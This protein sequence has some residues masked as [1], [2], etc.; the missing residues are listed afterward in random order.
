MTYLTV[1]DLKK[2]RELWERL[3]RERELIVTRDG[4]PCAIMVEVS[5]E[6]ADEALAEIRRALFSTAISRARRR[7][8][9][10]PA[11][12]HAIDSLVRKS[13]KRRG[14]S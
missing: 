6:N 2:T 9:Q 5:P 3:R 11:P 12:A 1:K 8:E 14:V 4:L 10:H 7:A 13:R